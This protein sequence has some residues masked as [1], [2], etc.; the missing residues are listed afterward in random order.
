MQAAQ[1][2]SATPRPRVRLIGQDGNAFM[3]LGLCRRAALHGGGWTEDQW[4]AFRDE[5]TRGDY[6]H[7]LTTVMDH[8]EVQ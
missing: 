3:I 1:A 2:H 7:L 6:T 8:F 4:R 5:A